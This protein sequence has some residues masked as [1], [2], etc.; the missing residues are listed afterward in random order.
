MAQGAAAKDAVS[1]AHLVL[2]HH[3]QLLLFGG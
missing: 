3:S 2:M 1:E